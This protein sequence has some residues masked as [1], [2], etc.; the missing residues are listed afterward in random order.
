MSEIN[1]NQRDAARAGWKAIKGLIILVVIVVAALIVFSLCTFTVGEAEQVAVIRFG[2]VSRVI[3]DPGIDFTKNNPDVIASLGNKGTN[4]SIIYGKGLFFRIP[5][6]DDVKKFDSRLLTYVSQEAKMNTNDK[7]QYAVT[8][9]AQW[10]IANPALFNQVYHTVSGATIVLDDTIEPTLVQSI[11]KMQATDFL[12]NKDELN[13]SLKDS[14][15]IMNDKMRSGGV[16]V[17]DVQVSRTLLPKENLQATYDR[18][19]A[20]REKVAQQLR[21]EGQESYQK[22]K[23]EADLEASKL[24]A[25]AT[26]QSKEIMGQ[27]DAQALQIYAESYSKD[28]EFYGFWRSLQAMKN[29]LGHDS[30]IV[31][32]RNSPLWK[33]LLDMI[34]TGTVTAK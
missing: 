6:V 10:R 3:L 4:V 34:G 27:A 29:S 18:M 25:D 2:T 13:S 17:V 11:N 5:F 9:Y 26:K 12:S 22:A 14:L 21:S 24:M 15:K 23:A 31:L 20:N 16:E 8:L 7:K 1:V 19:V 32:D 33:D 28:P 30:T